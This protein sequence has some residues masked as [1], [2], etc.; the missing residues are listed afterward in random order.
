MQTDAVD[1]AI[2]FFSWRESP[3]PGRPESHDLRI[4]W[5]LR[6][7]IQ[8]RQG[9]AIEMTFDNDEVACKG[10]LAICTDLGRISSPG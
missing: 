10:A 3:V 8:M 4:Y 5:M 6:F 9:N 2:G 1:V 7:S